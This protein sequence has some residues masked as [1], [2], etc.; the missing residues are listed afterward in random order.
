[1]FSLAV[2][3]GFWTVAVVIRVVLVDA[4]VMA[5]LPNDKFWRNTCLLKSRNCFEAAS[6]NDLDCSVTTAA[7]VVAT[8][9][10]RSALLVAAAFI[11]SL[12]SFVHDG[13]DDFRNG[14][15]HVCDF[16]CS[17]LMIAPAAAASA[18]VG[19]AEKVYEFY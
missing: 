15:R 1:M 4:V 10:A 16:C 6:K 2:A 3:S 9:L 18:Y 5:S 19:G 11:M 14:T 13:G 12:P 17:A 8:V 7:A